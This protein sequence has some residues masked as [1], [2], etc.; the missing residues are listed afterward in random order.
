MFIFV[1]LVCLVLE[2]ARGRC[3]FSGTGV[4]D[5]CELSCGLWDSNMSSLEEQAAGA[6]DF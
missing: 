6:L 4:K 3:R 2:E 5:S 1:H